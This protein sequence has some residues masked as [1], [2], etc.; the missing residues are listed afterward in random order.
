MK[1]P[2]LI[3]AF[4]L[5]AG[6][7]GIPRDNIEVAPLPEVVGFLIERLGPPEVYPGVAT[8]LVWDLG[9]TSLYVHLSYDP[10]GGWVIT[11]YYITD[12]STVPPEW[13]ARV[14]AA[15]TEEETWR[16]W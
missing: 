4:A 15:K 14:Y 13:M 5:L 2:I 10:F 1:W 8:T 9:E 12:N 6:C 11:S 16:D 7:A 3:L